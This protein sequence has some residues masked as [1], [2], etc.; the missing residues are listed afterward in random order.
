MARHQTKEGPNEKEE[1]T[2]VVIVDFANNNEQI[3]INR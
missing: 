1:G 2:L 3:Q